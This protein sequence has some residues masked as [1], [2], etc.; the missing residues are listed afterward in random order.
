MYCDKPKP[1]RPYVGICIAFMALMLSLG[2][3]LTAMILLATQPSSLTVMGII[4]A[5]ILLLSIC[6]MF[7]YFARLAYRVEYVISADSLILQVGK[8]FHETIPLASIV[9]AKRVKFIW[10]VLGY[11]G[12]A[13][14]YC[15][16]FTNGLLLKTKRGNVY[17]SPSNNEEFLLSLGLDVKD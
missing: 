10:R 1:S 14:G 12:F 5:D 7:F 6:A 4:L 15:N 16:R 17:I 2:F 9:G 8:F 3:I 13:R 11:G